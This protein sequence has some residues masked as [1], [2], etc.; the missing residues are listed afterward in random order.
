MI[1]PRKAARGLLALS[2]VFAIVPAPVALAADPAPTSIRPPAADDTMPVT[3]GKSQVMSVGSDITK[4]SITNPAIADVAVVSKRDVLINGK[5]PGT[6][7]LIVWTQK[8]RYSYDVLVRADANLLR[9]TL[10]RAL[11][12]KGLTVEITGDS[13]IL[14]GKVNT[15]SQI[16]MA[17]QIASGFAGKVINLLTATNV[18]QVQ[19]NV[20][21]VELNKNASSELGV[22]WGTMYRLPSGEDVLR[23]DESV[24]ATMKRPAGVDQP[25]FGI[26]ERIAARIKALEANGDAKILAKPNLVA[27]SG[28]KADFLVGGEIPIPMAQQMQ[29]VTFEW[30]PYGI[31]LAVE[32]RVLE[33]GRISMKVS[34]EVS[35]LD[36]NNAVRLTDF[37]VPAIS[38]R[39]ASTEVVLTP[40]QG[41]AIGGLM[42]N[43]ES[44]TVERVPLLGHIPIIGELFKSTRFQKNETELAILVTPEFV[45]E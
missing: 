31:K 34:P 8:G 32:P 30:K 19:V 15:T 36:Y 41:I 20:Q 9:S 22:K 35:T 45:G 40:G 6:T 33:D 14:I 1:I 3:V 28:G 27:V 16:K 13:V 18:Q 7:T 24:V 12:V 4:V 44:K 43:I 10:E 21:V 25:Y 11:K 38:S 23:P 39:R 2:M 5:Q 42:Q 26:Y 17:E 29:T 37:L